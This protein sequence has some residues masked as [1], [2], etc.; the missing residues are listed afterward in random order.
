[1]PV[2]WA[3]DLVPVALAVGLQACSPSALVVAVN[4]GFLP[5]APATSPVLLSPVHL[6]GDQTLPFV[7]LTFPL[8]PHL[9]LLIWGSSL[10]E[11]F[12]AMSESTKARSLGPHFSST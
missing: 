7:T 1:M 10:G 11:S 2:S 12:S 6:L 8:H 9:G 3:R 4:F 5:L